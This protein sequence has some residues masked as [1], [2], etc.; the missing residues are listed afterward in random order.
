MVT[1]RSTRQCTRE[2]KNNTSEKQKRIA[3]LLP[4]MRHTHHGSCA[5]HHH[6]LRRGHYIPRSVDAAV[7][8]CIHIRAP[9][10]VRTWKLVE[11]HGM[12]VRSDVGVDDRPSADP[13]VHCPRTAVHDSAPGAAWNC[14]VPSHTARGVA[15]Q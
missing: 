7:I 11:L 3:V 15:R 6:R 5:W 4:P 2:I 10:G 12:H 13:A 1:A 8:I 9:C 14:V